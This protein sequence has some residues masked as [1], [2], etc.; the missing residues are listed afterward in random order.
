[1]TSIMSI[2]SSSLMLASDQS[3]NTTWYLKNGLNNIASLKEKKPFYKE[4]LGS[5]ACKPEHDS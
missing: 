4:F 2:M 1:M 3:W 5:L